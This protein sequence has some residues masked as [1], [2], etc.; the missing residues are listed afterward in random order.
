MTKKAT[1]RMAKSATKGIESKPENGYLEVC[2]LN[3]CMVSLSQIV[4]YNDTNVLRQ[5]YDAILNN[6]NMENFPKD[7][8]LLEALKRI[9][10]TC[11]FYLLHAKDK[12]M[13][14]KK[15]EAR[16]RGALGRALGGNSI[17]AMIGT[18]NPWA[19]L[20]AAVT[21]VGVAAI[22]YKSERAKI[23]L[24]NEDKA[25]ELEKAALEQLHN[26]RKTL[27][28]TAWRLSKDHGFK[29]EYRLT[30]SQISV[31]NDI[32]AE[33]D[34]LCRYERLYQIRRLFDAYPLF[35][36]YLARAALETAEI[37][38]PL[39]CYLKAEDNKI[40]KNDEIG[41]GEC[42]ILVSDRER[43]E[44]LYTLY[45]NRAE[46]ALQKFIEKYDKCKLLREDVVAAAAYLD[47]V[48]FVEPSDYKE[49]LGRI[50]KAQKLAGMNFEIL[51]SCGVN[52]LV[53]LH[54]VRKS[55]DK[56]RDKLMLEAAKGA[57]YC[58]R[59][60][61]NENFNADINGRALSV[62]YKT[63]ANK[64][65][66]IQEIGGDD[67]FDPKANYATMKACIANRHSFV[68]RWMCPMSEEEYNKDW[69]AF[70]SGTQFKR[71]LARYMEMHL[72]FVYMD[73]YAALSKTFR[74]G[75]WSP[76]EALKDLKWGSRVKETS[77]QLAFDETDP[78]QVRHAV[79]WFS[80]QEKGGL[81]L[82]AKE[83]AFALAVPVI[84]GV[85]AS[86]MVAKKILKDVSLDQEN[87][88]WQS[89]ID[90]S[91][92]MKDPKARELFERVLDREPSCVKCEKEFLDSVVDFVNSSFETHFYT[93]YS[94]D[95]ERDY[96]SK[97]L[98][99]PLV[100]MEDALH[101]FAEVLALIYAAEFEKVY[102]NKCMTV[103][104]SDEDN[105][106]HHRANP[107]FSIIEFF[108]SY[109]EGVYNQLRKMGLP[110]IC[111]KR[112]KY[113]PTQ[114]RPVAQITASGVIAC[115]YKA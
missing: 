8:A 40:N 58:L 88:A 94:F 38:K 45:R 4:D 35:W 62:L 57:G 19:I 32:L 50:A 34:P 84:G 95:H 102:T 42:P 54:A 26:L 91:G 113:F 89:K 97:D 98:E 23:L 83:S 46:K 5:E 101:K 112:Y 74:E 16:L 27:F 78:K 15:Q 67:E 25:W 3:M 96:D 100:K 12:E 110:P 14:K 66:P 18:P 36:Y 99:A 111:T 65:D 115:G 56:K 49:K 109:S 108:E 28:E 82:I 43:N 60:L 20:G 1:T 31:Y 92:I 63:C 61:V 77:G 2:A 68:Y 30:E 10:D 81:S 104:I 17:V 37:Y 76:V 6:L 52:Y 29:D 44:N 85:V 69:T 72:R 114:E 55:D 64:D 24:E 39:Y 21:M 70:F 11:H 13:L 106:E 103:V 86:I 90:W 7:E 53:V 51:Q 73:V 80:R 71:T 93:L 105:V 79:T 9:L 87:A 59:L 41:I 47:S 107:V 33:S 48:Q 22:N 75:S